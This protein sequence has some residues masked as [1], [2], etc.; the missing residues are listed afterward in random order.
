MQSA[1][2]FC[3]H[4]L[5]VALMSSH[6]LHVTAVPYALHSHAG[7]YG[8]WHALAPLSHMHLLCIVPKQSDWHFE[9]SAGHLATVSPAWR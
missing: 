1:P 8:I 7:A 6:S 9:D 3:M 4:L 2:L 5:C